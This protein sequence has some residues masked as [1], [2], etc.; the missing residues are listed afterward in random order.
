MLRRKTSITKSVEKLDAAHKV[1]PLDL[2][3]DQDLTIA[4]MNLVAIEDGFSAP[5]ELIGFVHDVRQDLMARIVRESGVVWDM[6]W[7]LLV[8]S[9]QLMEQG[10]KLSGQDAYQCF[11]R[12]YELYSMFL[13]I[14]MGLISPKEVKK[15]VP[16]IDN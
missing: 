16:D 12:S 11:N 1:N 15:A 4:L 13:G 5:S 8:M 14:N 7:R 9:A 6:S 2:S 3:S 10:N